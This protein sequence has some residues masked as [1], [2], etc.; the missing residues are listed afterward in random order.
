[1]PVGII[2][3]AL[4]VFIGGMIGAFA[5]KGLSGRFKENLNMVFGCCSIA[6]GV[7]SISLMEN[8]PAVV[9]AT[10]IGT[11]I[12]LAVR[13]NERIVRAAGAMQ[14]LV[15]RFVKGGGSG[16]SEQEFNSLLITVIVLFC[17]SGTGIYGSIVSGMNGDHSI[18]ISKAVLDGPTALI[19]ACSLGVIAAF[20]AVPQFIVFFLLFLLARVIYPLTTPVMINDFKAVGGIIMIASGLRI[21]KLRECP[22]ADMIPAMILAMPVSW[23]WVT[24]IL[25]LVS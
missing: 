20:V 22:T 15:S 21:L 2:V 24:Y 4:A 25:P 14:R 9:F 12:G 13:L 7:S 3:N 17:A 18:L 6:M 8:M 1:M 23:F 10:I 5:G 16:L 19:F 11:C